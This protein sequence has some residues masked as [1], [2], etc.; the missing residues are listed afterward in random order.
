MAVVSVG[1]GGKRAVPSTHH[2]HVSAQLKAPSRESND[3]RFTLVVVNGLLK[4]T[5]ECTCNCG[6]VNRRAPWQEGNNIINT[7]ISYGVVILIVIATLAGFSSTHS[8][9]C[10]FVFFLDIAR[11][12]CGVCV[13]LYGRSLAVGDESDE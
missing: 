12:T 11:L 5:S 7:V 2:K 4:Q 8:F 13:P 10:L 3:A 1:G 9:F 6:G